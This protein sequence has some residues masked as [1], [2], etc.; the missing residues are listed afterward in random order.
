VAARKRDELLDG[1]MH[2]V[3][4]RGFA[5]VRMADIARELHCSLSSLYKVAPNKDSLLVLTI[6]RWGEVTL[7]AAE[8]SAGQATTAADR[9]RQYFLSA[10][11]SIG[12]LSHAFRRDVEHFESTRLA[13][14]SVSDLFVGRF[15]VLLDEAARSGEIR[16]F[17]P[18][19]LAGLFR[20]IAAAIRDEDLLEASGLTASE[21]LIEVDAL[22]WG[23]LAP[24]REE[25]CSEASP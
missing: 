23:G 24:P 17:N 2:M 22:V 13:Y 19:F 18:R 20:H 3:E 25:G 8:T 1:V 21:A 15:A 7:E 10:A 4:T 12:G 14:R 9:A 6:T 5:H 16:S 11:R